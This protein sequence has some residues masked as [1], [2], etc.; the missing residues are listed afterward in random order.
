MMNDA[1]KEIKLETFYNSIAA[2]SCGRAATG[3]QQWQQ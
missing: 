3:Q 1:E 2:G